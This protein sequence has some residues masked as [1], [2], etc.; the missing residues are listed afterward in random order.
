[1]LHTHSLSLL[2][3]SP[4]EEMSGSNFGEKQGSP[5]EGTGAAD[6]KTKVKIWPRP[7]L[8]R[9]TTPESWALSG[10]ENND[11]GVSCPI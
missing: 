8:D 9:D 7:F 10:A 4:Q 1:M 2:I 3:K 11:P 6:S 5:Q